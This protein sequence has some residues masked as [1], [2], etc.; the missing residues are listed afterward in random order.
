MESFYKE[1]F[2]RELVA[3]RALSGNSAKIKLWSYTALVIR[4]FLV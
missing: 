3:M 1:V 2:Q 4:T